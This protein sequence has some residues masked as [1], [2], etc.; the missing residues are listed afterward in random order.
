MGTFKLQLTEE[1]WYAA[2][3]G[4][5]VS[6]PATLH[7][8]LHAQQPELYRRLTARLQAEHEAAR[9]QAEA[10]KKPAKAAKATEA[11]AAE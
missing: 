8:S 4:D 5:G 2:L 11:K 1:Q 3:K 7:E 9:R 10:E 6:V